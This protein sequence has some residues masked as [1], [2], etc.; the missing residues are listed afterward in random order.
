MPPNRFRWLRW[1]AVDL[2]AVEAVAET[3]AAVAE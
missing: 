1:E 2:R 3:Q